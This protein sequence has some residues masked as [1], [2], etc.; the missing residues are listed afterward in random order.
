MC[1]QVCLCMCVHKYV[2]G[3]QEPTVVIVPSS[4]QA[5]I[6]A[7][8]HICTCKCVHTY[9]CLSLHTC[10]NVGVNQV[11]YLL[12]EELGGVLYNVWVG[13]VDKGEGVNHFLNA[14][15]LQHFAQLRKQL[16]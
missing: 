3:L 2:L 1:M 14:V 7:G 11:R 15:Q 10:I 8:K 12:L 5:W 9:R 13:G 4:M 6:E 16:G